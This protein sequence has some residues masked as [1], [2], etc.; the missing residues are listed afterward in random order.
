ME[1]VEEPLLLPRCFEA[2]KDT[3]T[4]KKRKNLKINHVCFECVEILPGTWAAL[5]HKDKPEWRHTVVRKSLALHC[6]LRLTHLQWRKLT[7]AGASQCLCFGRLFPRKWCTFLS[8]HL[9]RP[10]YYSY[11]RQELTGYSVT[12]SSHFASCWRHCWMTW[13]RRMRSVGVCEVRAQ[14]LCCEAEAR[15]QAA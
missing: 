6:S 4:W 5:F 15:A 11:W 13:T 2:F 8:L 9:Q 7:H 12:T 14:L 3:Y 10:H 1:T